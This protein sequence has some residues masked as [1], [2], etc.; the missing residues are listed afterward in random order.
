MKFFKVYIN[1]TLDRFDV[2]VSDSNDINIVPRGWYV[3]LMVSQI[4]HVHYDGLV[5][6]KR[7]NNDGMKG[8]MP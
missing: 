8:W 6:V 4:H 2:N 1:I 7:W 5:T 3:L